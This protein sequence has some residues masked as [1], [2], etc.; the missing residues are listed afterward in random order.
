MLDRD[1]AQ[2][3]SIIDLGEYQDR[4]LALY[5]SAVTGWVK[6]KVTRLQRTVQ[7]TEMM[8]D[9]EPQ[10]CLQFGRTGRR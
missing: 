7:G 1:A 8:R 6:D 2:G 3:D 5:R 9:S 10:K 4:I